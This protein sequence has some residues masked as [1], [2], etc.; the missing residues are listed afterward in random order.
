MKILWIGG[1][2]P[3]HLYYLNRIRRDFDIAGAILEIREEI[4]PSPPEGTGKADRSNFI[5]H[6]AGREKAE[7]RYFG[8]QALPDCPRHDVIRASGVAEDLNSPESA[9]FVRRIAPDIALIFGCSLIKDPLKSALPPLTVNLHLGL[10]PWYRGGATLFWPFYFMEPNF[11]GSTF[12]FIV[13]EPDAGDIIHQSVPELSSE[14]GIHD[15]ACKTVV[16]SSE[17][18]VRLLKI[19]AAGG[20]WDR[21]RQKGTGKKF[22]AQRFQARTP[23]G[24]L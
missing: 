10:S 1:N 23:E 15:V 19:A 13:N 7:G 6:F 12:H 9:E 20:R 4:I 5:R 2:H 16:A 22:P 14:D 17:D 3:R 11:A 24:H 21:Y 18:A 8:R